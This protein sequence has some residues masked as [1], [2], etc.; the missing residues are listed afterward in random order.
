MRA[1]FVAICFG[2]LAILSGCS[3]SSRQMMGM[4]GSSD[5]CVLEYARGD[6]AALAKR[7]K[8]FSRLEEPCR[9]VVLRA[10]AEEDPERLLGLA[11]DSGDAGLLIAAAVVAGASGKPVSVPHRSRRVLERS[12]DGRILLQWILYNDLAVYRGQ[13]A[14]A[15]A[16]VSA[17]QDVARMIRQGSPDEELR[18]AVRRLALLTDRAIGEAM[19]DEKVP[20]PPAMPRTYTLRD[21]GLKLALAPYLR[22]PAPQALSLL[23]DS[24]ERTTK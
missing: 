7:A 20:P 15:Q 13:G 14:T 9:T 6:Y 5:D 1:V 3:T 21:L 4:T 23:V 24:Q 2:T 11:T 22:T 16:L 18:A 12:R 8:R 17:R 19:L 10:V